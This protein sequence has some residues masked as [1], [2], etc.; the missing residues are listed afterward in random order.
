M[1]AAAASS[2][3]TPR[4]RTVLSIRSDGSFVRVARN[5]VESLGRGR[6]SLMLTRRFPGPLYTHNSRIRALH[7]ERSHV[8]L[9]PNFDADVGRTCLE[10]LRRDRNA[11][12]LVRNFRTY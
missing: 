5:G 2:P 11:G 1:S 3:S 7:E 12:S 9:T 8:A 10:K 6:Q 4:R